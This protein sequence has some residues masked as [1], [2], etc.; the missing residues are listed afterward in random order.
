MCIRD[1]EKG[2]GRRSAPS[3]GIG[4]MGASWRVKKLKRLREQAK[5]DGLNFENLVMEHFGT[6]EVIKEIDQQASRG[7]ADNMA[8]RRAIQRRMH[9]NRQN[10]GHMRDV[11]SHETRRAGMMRAPSSEGG[12]RFTSRGHRRQG[13]TNENRIADD[14]SFLDKMLKGSDPLAAQPRKGDWVCPKCAA[15]V[16]AHKEKCFKC[17]T[18]K[19]SEAQIKAAAT[20]AL[21]ASR[22]PRE[23]DALDRRRAQDAL[24]NEASDAFVDANRQQQKRESA[25][26]VV[27]PTLQA[28]AAKP[29]VDVNQLA[30]KAM[31]AKLMGKHELHASLM[32]QVEDVKK[33]IDIAE[34]TVVM[35]QVDLT[36]QLIHEAQGGAPT[37]GQREHS[38]AKDKKPKKTQCYDKGERN[39]Y[40]ADDDQKSLTDLVKES[41]TNRHTSGIDDNFADNVIRAGTKYKGQDVDDEYEHDGALAAYESRKSRMS[42][43]KRE[44]RQR[45]SAIRQT[46]KIQTIQ[47]RCRMCWANASRDGVIAAGTKCYLA[48]PNTG[49]LVAGHCWILPREHEVCSRLFDDDTF[50]EMRNF[51]KCLLRAFAAQQQ[52]CLFVE[53]VPNIA[54]MKHGYVECIPLPWGKAKQAPAYFKQALE[55]T[56]A[57]S[58]FET[59]H[60]R[61]IDTRAKGLN[62]SIPKQFPYF[63]VEFGIGGGYA[64]IIE[65]ASEWQNEKAGFAYEIAATMMKLPK[66]A[67][68][69]RRSSAEEMRMRV[70]EFNKMYLKYDWTGMLKEDK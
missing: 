55:L 2:D 45:E 70:E 31:R 25:P 56:D 38:F 7:S 12:D 15:N 20:A 28:V 5:E 17:L 41:K 40:F 6:L 62:A 21:E 48:L 57:V 51:K 32:K 10:S 24:K 37:Q 54:G 26:T 13:A 65:D 11:A 1:R 43:Q 64:H 3:S 27:A 61:I 47:D 29:E 59:T 44:Q 9:S 42:E 63:H 23:M 68:N 16:F 36:G 46:Q 66:E 4:D 53:T 19:P 35:A 22:P 69:L 67:L 18:P 58:E 30:A 60:K 34:N 33:G 14:G 39:K 8:H 52:D 50:Q 49:S